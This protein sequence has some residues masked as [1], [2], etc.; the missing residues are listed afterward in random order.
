MDDQSE[1]VA[2]LRGLTDAEGRPAEVVETHGALIFLCGDTALKLKRAV[3]YD[4]MD[5]ST[6][7]R[8]KALLERELE[9]N[10]PSAP[11]IYRD[12]VPVTRGPEGL[13]LGGEGAPAE[14]LLRMARFPAE[15][16]LAV[17]AARQGIGDGLAEALGQAVQRYHHAAPLRAAEGPKLIADILDELARVFA[18]M[19]AV[20]GPEAPAR[21]DAEARATLD[22]VAP[23]LARRAAEGHVRR[24]HG[25]LHLGNLVLIDGLPTPFDALEFDE[26]L[27]TCDVLYDLAFL[28][29][30]LC[31]RDLRQAADI[32]LASWL[33]QAGG[34]E[35]AGLGALPLFLAVRA[36]IRA[37]VLVQTDAARGST[38]AG[39]EARR[40]LDEALAALR[41]APP[42][43]V[44]VGGRSG[45]GKTT[46][47]RR[48]APWIGALPGAVHL[49]SDTERK[50]GAEPVDYSPEGRARIYARML[51]R[52]SCLL[53]AGQS[54][55]LDATFLDEADR[56]AAERL[57]G[58]AGVPFHGLWLEA[59]P[60]I[61]LARV[62]SRR[63]DASDADAAVVEAQLSDGTE[64]EE[65]LRI[66]AGDGLE[67][68]LAA[69]RTALG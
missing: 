58:T 34:T 19:E 64:P 17:I 26:V 7:A 50:A 24:C 38:E 18:G 54:V 22:R 8:R 65:W 15:D 37:M 67:P 30:D 21:F 45:S 47:A 62:A 1:T 42:R 57:A 63:G 69:A 13:R 4:Y 60:A 14:W 43:L 29:M 33:L 28:L 25:D 61:L 44:A 52:A 27:G 12:L 2:F 40:L 51:E 11:K 23:L 36:A 6:L 9:L 31:H 5:L 48:L 10:R 68:A 66:D 41:P 3:V 59:P 20:L 56:A 49:R 39:P 46:L 16:E 55:L 53:G 32:T 35:D